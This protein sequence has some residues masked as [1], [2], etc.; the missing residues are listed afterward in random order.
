VRDMEL[1]DNRLDQ[2][3]NINARF[4]ADQRAGERGQRWQ[5]IS[6]LL[7]I[8]EFLQAEVTNNYAARE[9]WCNV[10]AA[11]AIDMRPPVTPGEEGR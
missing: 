2:I 8:V 10:A 11:L 5:D 3:R 6:D 4:E 1:S 9:R 7:D